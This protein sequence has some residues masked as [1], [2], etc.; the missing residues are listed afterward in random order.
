MLYSNHHHISQSKIEIKLLMNIILRLSIVLLSLVL[1]TGCATSRQ[2]I[3]EDN[4][5]RQMS[6]AASYNSIEA[7]S[8][9][10]IRP[11]DEIEILVWE[12]PN[13]NTNTTV[14]NQGTIV[15]PL[16]GEMKITGLTQSELKRDLNRQLAQYIRGEINLT[17]SVRSTDNMEVSVFGMVADPDNYQI[18]DQTSIFKVLSMAGG[19]SEDANIRR[20]KVYRKSGDPKYHLIDLTYYLEHGRMDEAAMILP[21]DIIYVPQRQNAVREM[22]D[23][24]RDVVLLFGIFRVIN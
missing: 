3:E 22:S 1:V 7:D 2:Q 20:V 6:A 4:A 13:F 12:Q 5:R 18:V 24:L 16:I 23:F 21:G 15:V 19:P 11:G 10:K 14:A 17:V 8:A 9:Y